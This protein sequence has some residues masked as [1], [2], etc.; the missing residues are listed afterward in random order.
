MSRPSPTV[1]RRIMLVAL[2][3]VA[4]AAAISVALSL[5]RQAE[6]AA[7]LAATENRLR[8]LEQEAE[9]TATDNRLLRERLA[10]LGEAP[11]PAPAV[12]RRADAASS[13]EQ[14][15]LLVKLQQELSSTENAL[16]EAELRIRELEEKLARAQEDSRRTLAA[17]E[18]HKE[19]LAGQS[20][21]LEAVQAELKSRNERLVQLEATNLTLHKQHRQ[22]EEEN[23][24][25]RAALRELEEINR[26]RENAIVAIMRRYRELGDQFRALAVQPGGAGEAGGTPGADFSRVQSTLAMVE[27]ELRQLNS[28]NA[29]AARLQR[30]LERK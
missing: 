19:K 27:E 1:R 26:R 5:R 11:P 30:Q 3:A 9:Q 14:A 20:R 25:Q 28:L 15:R 4:A 13:L 21:V 17:L 23:A 22:A 2:A 16:R 24:R 10:E 8:E 18:E 12:P 29:Q 6:L 7:K